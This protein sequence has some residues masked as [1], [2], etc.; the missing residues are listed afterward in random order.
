MRSV[1]G[2]RCKNLQLESLQL[3]NWADFFLS[4]HKVSSG[5]HLANS[6]TWLLN[7][8]SDS[9]GLDNKNSDYYTLYHKRSVLTVCQQRTFKQVQCSLHTLLACMCACVSLCVPFLLLKALV[10]QRAGAGSTDEVTLDDFSAAVKLDLTVQTIWSL[11]ESTKAEKKSKNYVAN[12]S[13]PLKY[14]YKSNIISCK[15]ELKLLCARFTCLYTLM[16]YALCNLLISPYS[17]SRYKA[18]QTVACCCHMKLASFQT[19]LMI[20][21]LCLEKQSTNLIL[22]TE[23]ENKDLIS[24]RS[25]MNQ[26]TC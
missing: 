8:F 10:Q 24:I 13:K 5:D 25:S 11:P 21:S 2:R 16:C 4:H 20:S 23:I 12:V 22:F 7:H 18:F 17:I 3:E 1:L 19:E 6:H 15:L 9:C 26:L 14:T